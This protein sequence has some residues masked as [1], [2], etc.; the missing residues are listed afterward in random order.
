MFEIFFSDLSE[1]AQA[2]LMAFAGITDPKEM[3][4]DV[5]ICP[6]AIISEPEGLA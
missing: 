3:N 1:E 6:L 5:D 2:R 4:W